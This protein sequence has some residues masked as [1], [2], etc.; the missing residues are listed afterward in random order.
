MTGE[1]KKKR[2]GKTKHGGRKDKRPPCN[3]RKKVGESLVFVS[4][5]S[6]HVTC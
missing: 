6:Q 2:K 4:G 3:L 1:K 5:L